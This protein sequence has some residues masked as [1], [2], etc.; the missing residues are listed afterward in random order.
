ML[1]IWST[2]QDPNKLKKVKKKPSK[3]LALFLAHTDNAARRRA[4]RLPGS[5][6]VKLAS[7]QRYLFIFP[8][9]ALLRSGP[10]DGDVC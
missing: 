4:A 8:S 6:Q 3:Q 10:D 9:P 2:V 7:Y 1:Y 5:K